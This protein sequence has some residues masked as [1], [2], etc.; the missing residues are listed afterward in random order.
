M[1]LSQTRFMKRIYHLSTCDTCRRILRDLNPPEDFER[2]EIR[3]NP[4][5]TEE[6]EH[7]AEL[8]GSY[9]ALFNSRARLCRERNIKVAELSEEEIRTLI[10]E[11]YTLLKRPVI[12]QDNKIFIGNSRETVQRA[13]KSLLH[14]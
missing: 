5:L 10:L 9:K 13:G 12:V 6:L 14:R 3:K 11:H 8:S 1:A 7:L 4:V 2:R